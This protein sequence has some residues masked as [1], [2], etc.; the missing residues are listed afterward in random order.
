MG[1]LVNAFIGIAHLVLVAADIV[2]MMILLD[3]IYRRW[4][5]AILR[6]AVIA[7]RPVLECVLRYFEIC[8]VKISGK[9]YPQKTLMI[10]LIVCM[11]L[12]RLVICGLL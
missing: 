12:L 7:I 3:A 1:L 2:V 9:T 5:P 4:Q 11:T 10:L 8:T 6:P